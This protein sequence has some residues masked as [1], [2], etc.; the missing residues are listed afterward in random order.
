MVCG[1]ALLLSAYAI[2]FQC[3]KAPTGNRQMLFG[4]IS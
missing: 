2:G 3:K 4:L 1:G